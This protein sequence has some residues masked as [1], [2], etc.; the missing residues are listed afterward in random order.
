VRRGG[1][2]ESVHVVHAAASQDGSIV[3][4]AGDPG[5]VTFLR[6]SAKPFQA[7]LLTRVRPDLDE[8]EL[9]IAC[10][11]HHAEPVQLEAVRG[12]LAKAPA[13]EDDLE[14][15][16][17]AGRPSGRL[18]HNCSG[19]H[20]GMLALCRARGWPTH[21][22]RLAEHPLQQEILGEVSAAAALE[23]G[24]AIDGCGVITFALPLEAMA[25]MFSRLHELEGGGAVLAA[26]RA[27]P[28]LIGGELSLDTR[29]MRARPGW[30]A[31]GGAE[32]LMCGVSADGVGFAL[33]VEDGNQRALGPALA[34]FLEVDEVADVPVLNSRGEEVGEVAIS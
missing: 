24:T 33:K 10:A 26:M 7:L 32:G 3:S 19:K 4:A 6:S 16:E 25:R 28:E 31:K 17:Q 20:A 21:G 34:A 2:V 13:T 5:F 9:A 8:A 22:Y 18:H 14:C 29:L 27:R 15:G 11:S 30:V 1:L 12:L 23:P